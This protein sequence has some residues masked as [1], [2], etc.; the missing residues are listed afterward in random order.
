MNAP[1]HKT[2]LHALHSELGARLVPFA[3]HAM[4]VSYP[5]GIIREHLHTRTAA[6]FF[7]VSHMGQV[8]VRGARAAEAL[9]ALM[10]IDVRGL[11]C[12]R[13]RY[14]FLTTADGGVID[15]L[16]ITRLADRFFLVVNASRVDAD[17]AHLHQQLPADVT[18]QPLADR[19]LLALQGP[20]AEAVLAVD[21]PAVRE[22]RFMDV[23]EARLDGQ[24]CLIAR[25]GYT[26]EDGFEIALPAAGAEALARRWLAAGVRPAGLGARDSLRLEAGLCLYGHEL[27]EQTSPVAAGLAWAIPAVRR[28]GGARAGGFPG[29]ERILTELVQGTLRRRVGLLPEGRA[30]LREGT[31]LE[32]A[33]GRPI[34]C[35][36]SGTFS[37]SLQRPLAC[38][39]IDTDWAEPGRQ[40]QARLRGKPVSVTVG[41]PVQ[42]A[43]RYRRA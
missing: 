40:C 33:E 7:D 23:I 29:A 27:D 28:R 18:L 32:D 39:Y 31:V 42:V 8:E 20:D 11:V 37:P 30:P 25:S 21:C 9:E 41:T 13:Q 1:L 22:M 26:G 17:L 19:A 4:P 2:P 6:S 43:H 36:T 35:I 3:G 5:D 12:G 16:M 24:D 10:P 34:G 38:G 14:G 15:D